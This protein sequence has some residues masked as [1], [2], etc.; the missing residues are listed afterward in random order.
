[1]RKNRVVT[2]LSVAFLCI[3]SASCDRSIEEIQSHDHNVRNKA[4]EALGKGATEGD[5]LQLCKLLVG[6]DRYEVRSDCAR[7]LSYLKKPESV[8]Y[9]IEALADKHWL[10]RRS[11][12]DALRHV[13]DER[14]S[15]PLV[16]MLSDTEPEIQRHAA[17]AFQVFRRSETVPILVDKLVFENPKDLAEIDYMNREALRALGHQREKRALPA[18]R[19]MLDYSHTPVSR[20]AADAVGA[21]VGQEFKEDVWISHGFKAPLGSPTKAKTWLAEHP[22][23]LQDAVGSRSDR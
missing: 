15:Q 9:L 5:V 13:G 12:V 14:A 1:M 3:I 2:L 21:I 19:K 11:A 22:E 7:T 8:P 6:S 17:M 10:V 18:L 4:I 23:V 20:D 16:Q